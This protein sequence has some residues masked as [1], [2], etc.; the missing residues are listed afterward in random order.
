MNHYFSHSHDIKP[1]ES[2]Y[3]P[4]DHGKLFYQ[5]F[6]KGSPVVIVHG[7][8]LDHSYLLPQMLELSQDHQVII[9]DQRG[10]GQSLSS[11]IYPNDVSVDQFT[12]DLESLRLALKQEQLTLIGH[13]WGGFLSMNYT[14][15]YPKHVSSLILMSSA[16][17]DYEGQKAFA[18]ELGK[19]MMSMQHQLKPL[20]TYGGLRHLSDLEVCELYRHMFSI[21]LKNPL[22]VDK[23]TVSMTQESAMNGMQVLYM[24]LQTSYGKPEGAL[25]SYLKNICIPTLIIHGRQDIVP[26]SSAQKIHHAIA[27]SIMIELDDCGH[28]PHVEKTEET[29]LAIKSFLGG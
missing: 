11:K 8:G 20:L 4:I 19:R 1:T 28:F 26:V 27:Q 15:H 7:A 17:A 21:Y 14:I 22:D 6:G 2:G 25:I 5:K 3:V 16:A 12:K 23:L 18:D 24:M 29:L 9:Y 13:S 10:S